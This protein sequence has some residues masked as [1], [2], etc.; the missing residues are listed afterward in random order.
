MEWAKFIVRLLEGIAN[1][2]NRK[3]KRSYADD[4]G[5]TISNGGS[6]QHSEQSF[7]D[8]ADKPKRDR[9]E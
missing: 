5:N 6:V 4:S 8:L 1:V 3:K 2:T 7:S 9:S